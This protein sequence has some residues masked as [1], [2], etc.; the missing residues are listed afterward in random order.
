MRIP[1]LA[2]CLSAALPAAAQAPGHAQPSSAGT[3]AEAKSFV[4]RVN[5]DL[6][7]LWIR[8]GTADWI[9]ATYITDDAERNAA[10][11]N[12][13]V[14]AYL[15]RAI[16]DSVR[17]DGVDVDPD[18]RRM[19][20]L[21]RVASP[22]PAPSDPARRG[23]LA[24]IAAKL[25]GIY[26]KGKVCDPIRGRNGK[27]VTLAKGRE[28]GCRDLQDLEEILAK[29][30]DYDA[31][32]A[33]WTGWHRISRQ[34]KP[35]YARMVELSNEGAREIGFRD[36]GEL[37]RA[38]YDMSPG[39]FEADEERLWQEVKP[40]YA[41]LH[42]YVR[43]KLQKV[44][45]KDRVP[46]GGP[47][48]A[49]LL[50]NMWAQGWE[51]LYPLVEPYPG[52]SDVDV[53]RALKTQK[54]DPIRMVR[55]GEAF[56][57]SLGFD[58]LPGS[59]WERSMFTKPRDREVVCHASAWDVTWS[60][61]LR[62]KMCIR[63]IEEDLVTIHH[64]LGHNFYQRAY[65]Q[66]PTLFAAGAN[67]G[68]HEA[69]GDAVALS[70]T[71]GYLKQLGLV[72]RLPGDDRGAVNFQMKKALEKVAFLPWGKLVDQ[73]RWDVFAGKV[74]PDQYDQAWWALRERVQ[75]VARPV[76]EVA[77]DFDPGA[78][79]H[80]PANVPYARYFL[81][82][83]YQFQFYKALCDASGWKG[84]LHQCSF[85]G[86]KEAGKKF[87]T[88][89]AMGASR[90]WPEAYAALTGTRKPDAAP[91]LEYFA[92]LRAFLEKENAGRQCGW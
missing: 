35:L 88:M 44:Y 48:P 49:H 33:A 41:Q 8:S 58:P 92:P 59:F 68:F 2:L 3:P 81:A 83:I 24:G 64:E 26:G 28:G 85:Y 18:T 66:L 89:L 30:R 29:S 55:T 71:P 7:R 22:L 56:F 50:G 10:A 69:I 36:T 84:P 78:K 13:D 17:F 16:R 21:L 61:D 54:W 45:G 75:G 4:D 74:T 52:A 87:Q 76:P 63:P 37:W 46:G 9:K 60:G 91:M 47:I 12:E 86:S 90:P 79:Y 57:T 15:S 1:V 23:E 62:I 34:M 82:A 38:G 53:D 39:E 72:D 80:V 27:A 73:W 25:E 65:V 70:I 14:M 31:L 42:C 6:K 77:G 40:L 32:L 19:L 51:N 67:D 43:A 20:Y 5:S 11:L